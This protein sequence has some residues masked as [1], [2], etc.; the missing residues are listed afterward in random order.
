M[1]EGSFID[2]KD[3]FIYTVARKIVI[4][5][6][7]GAL[8]A[9]KQ[10][11]DKVKVQED[12]LLIFLGDYV[13]GWSESAQVI[14]YLIELEKARRCIFL[15]GNHDA[16]CDDWLNGKPANEDWLFHGGR[17]TIKSYDSVTIEQRAVHLEFFRRLRNYYEDDDNRLFIHAGF[18]SMHGPSRERHESNCYWDRTLWELALATDN[19]IHK[20]SKNYPKRLQHY[21]EIY[22]GHTPTVNWDTD[23]PMNACN[24]W[25]IDTGAAFTGKLTA[26]DVDTKAFWQSATVQRLY[27]DEKGRNG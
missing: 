5:D 16:W 22:I 6:I 26:M 27:P 24:V 20:D 9:L 19:R 13:D 17:S 18:S 23:L 8:K 1:T 11:L 12:D 2:F 15:R 7:H 3:R 4:G 10:V 25:N 21:R 14:R